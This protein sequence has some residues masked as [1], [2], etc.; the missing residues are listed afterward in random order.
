MF[1]C[2]SVRLDDMCIF[3]CPE[4]FFFF[5]ADTNVHLFLSE[6]TDSIAFHANVQLL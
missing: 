1:M 4:L 6:I 5:K 3:T 2:V